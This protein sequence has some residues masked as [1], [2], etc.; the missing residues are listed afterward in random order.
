MFTHPMGWSWLKGMPL[1][2]IIPGI[3]V[4]R[5]RVNRLTGDH[6]LDVHLSPSLL[7]GAHWDGHKRAPKPGRVVG[8]GWNAT[9]H[10]RYTP[11]IDSYLT[12]ASSL[13]DL[14]PICSSAHHVAPRPDP[15]GEGAFPR[16]RMGQV[17]RPRPSP[18][19]SCLPPRQNPK[20]LCQRTVRQPHQECL[21]PAGDGPQR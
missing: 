14:L 4:R 8:I 19:N 5:R 12:T 11:H 17:R 3:P 20:G 13:S 15:R 21:D 6:D 10:H 7:S 9:S 16:A 1:P 18:P 2:R